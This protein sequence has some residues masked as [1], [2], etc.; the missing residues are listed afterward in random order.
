L[1]VG[2]DKKGPKKVMVAKDLPVGYDLS[3]SWSQKEF[4]LTYANNPEA[5]DRRFQQDSQADFIKSGGEMIPFE[6]FIKR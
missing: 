2:F 3:A 6:Q 1:K 4:H 5:W